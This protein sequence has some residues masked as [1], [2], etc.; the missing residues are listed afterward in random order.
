MAR[1]I[2]CRFCGAQATVIAG[3]FPEKCANRSCE[4]VGFWSTQPV[5]VTMKDRRKHK[6]PRVPYDLNHNDIRM[7]RAARIEP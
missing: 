1:P 3:V 2:W 5:S 4:E 6:R 7:L